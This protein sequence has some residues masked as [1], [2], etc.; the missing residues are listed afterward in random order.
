MHCMVF[1][2]VAAVSLSLQMSWAWYYKTA[3]FDTALILLPSV[4]MG[5]LFSSVGGIN[6]LS[7]AYSVYFTLLYRTAKIALDVTC[8]ELVQMLFVRIWKSVTF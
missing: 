6:H 7:P 4:V 3:A 1:T 5:E 2:R 8:C